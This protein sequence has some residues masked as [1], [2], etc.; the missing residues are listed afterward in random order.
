M[1]TIDSQG[2]CVAYIRQVHDIVILYNV[3]LHTRVSICVSVDHVTLD[4][5]HE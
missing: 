2:C 5:K 4:H 1:Q 3:V